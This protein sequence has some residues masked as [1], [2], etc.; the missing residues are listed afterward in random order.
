MR[1][2]VCVSVLLV[3]GSSM[4]AMAETSVTDVNE[5]A[6][7]WCLSQFPHEDNP[8]AADDGKPLPHPTAKLQPFNLRNAI[9]PPDLVTRTEVVGELPPPIEKF[10]G[11]WTW[12]AVEGLPPAVI[13]VERL[14]STEMTIATAFNREKGL[15]EADYEV[16]RMTLSWTGTHFAYSKVTPEESRQVEIHV[17]QSG[18]A[19]FMIS[20]YSRVVTL[21]GP[22]GI[23]GTSK[24]PSD[25]WPTCFI[26]ERHY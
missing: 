7:E 12:P 15:D 22:N 17:S 3:V 18:E 20:G 9:A 8:W 13:F 11:H 1:N 6:F 14:T 25:A 5:K 21:E 16:E 10:R 19:M 24:V 2:L 26:S 23:V 4:P